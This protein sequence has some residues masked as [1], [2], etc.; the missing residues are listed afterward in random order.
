LPKEQQELVLR[1]WE[2]LRERLQGYASARVADAGDVLRD[3][4]LQPA[5]PTT[6]STVRR[7]Y[8]WALEAYEAAGK[9]PTR[10]R[11]CRTWRQR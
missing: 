7:N 5:G 10:R 6:Q 3:A 1:E 8:E 9:L 11:I 2:V 4:E